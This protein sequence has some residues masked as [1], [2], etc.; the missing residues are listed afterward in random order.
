MKWG[1]R[2]QLKKQQKE[3]FK[4]ICKAVNRNKWQGSEKN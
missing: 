1:V 4:E 2:R 3:N